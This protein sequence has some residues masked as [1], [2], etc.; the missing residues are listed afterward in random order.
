[1]TSGRKQ[2]LPESEP[3]PPAYVLAALQALEAAGHEAWLVGGCVR[4]FLLGVPP[5]DYDIATGA[6]PEQVARIFPR[7]LPTGEKFGCVTVLTDGGPL[8]VTTFRSEAGYAD[9]R[10][11]D[12]VRPAGT[13]REDVLRRDFT[14]GAIA[15]SPLRG[16]RDD[17]GG[18][19]DLR[20]GLIRAVGDPVRRFS[21][22]SLRILRAVRFAAR[23]DFAIEPG[24]LRAM[25]DCAAGLQ[26]VSRERIGREL[27][28][29]LVSPRPEKLA[30]LADCGALGFLGIPAGCRWEALPRVP[31]GAPS[32]LACLSIISGTPA[33]EL[34]GALRLPKRLSSA[35]EELCGLA[36]A[37]LPMD[38][39]GVKR[40]MA[41]HA[42][43]ALEAAARLR[44]AV[45]GESSETFLHIVK[46][47]TERG[48]PCSLRQLAADG[49]D[50]AAAGVPAKE[51]GR[52]LERL[53]ETVV[54][55]PEKNLRGELLRQVSLDYP[56][57]R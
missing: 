41:R 43:E 29:T 28:G 27:Q 39:A 19:E 50:L 33:R 12:E 37:P 1:M 22:D 3:R 40:R 18:I 17:T 8:E 42:P 11:P 49:G 57:Q 6:L 55:A 9:G 26:R 10:H 53:L 52:E 2:N 5:Q 24:T 36:A 16:W 51:I 44:E 38:R 14:I 30:L 4:D 7:V 54:E 35:A 47:V 13:L 32:R 25:R 46:D 23:L 20:A 15:W 34:G 56:P 48:E 31:A 21:E 45:T